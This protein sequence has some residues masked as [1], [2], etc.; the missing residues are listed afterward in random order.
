MTTSGKNVMI[1]ETLEI[2]GKGEEETERVEE[3]KIGGRKMANLT[4]AEAEAS[5]ILSPDQTV[6]AP[7]LT[8][9]IGL[10]V[11]VN[12]MDITEKEAEA[13]LN[14]LTERAI[15]QTKINL[16][17]G[18]GDRELTTNIERALNL[19][20]MKGQNQDLVTMNLD[21]APIHTPEGHPKTGM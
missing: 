17:K 15:F 11:I 6:I 16:D 3:T 7:S 21:L 12:L 4:E 18:T 13:G 5:P 20:L 8:L 9:S 14:P 1:K 2:R 10:E 19:Y